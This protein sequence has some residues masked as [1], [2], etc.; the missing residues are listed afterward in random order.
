MTGYLERLVGRHAGPPAVWPRPVS[1][2][3]GDHVGTEIG[4]ETEVRVSD[5]GPSA[6]A[7]KAIETAATVVAT[8]TT[9]A[10]FPTV[11][12]SGRS[13]GVAHDRIDGPRPA[14]AAA[15]QAPSPATIAPGPRRSVRRSDRARRDEPATRRGQEG[16]TVAPVT[17]RRAGPPAIVVSTGGDAT[18]TRR[19][20]GLA[21]PEPD[22]VHVH[23][24][25]VEVRAA[26]PAREPS[27]PAPRPAR[28]GPLSLDRYLS[29]ERR[30]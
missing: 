6:A 29:G 3:E 21:P 8:G 22:V 10:A 20:A 15:S 4:S 17:I 14:G 18:P 16:S 27:R 28:P 30:T 24:G 23:I 11:A 2:F 19:S 12:S 13:D 9:D 26:V 25:R 5:R 7:P 1:R